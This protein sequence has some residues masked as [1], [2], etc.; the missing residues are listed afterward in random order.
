MSKL[1]LALMVAMAA[2]VIPGVGIAQAQVVEYAPPAEEIRPEVGGL[3]GA[4]ASD[5][6]LASAAGLEVLKAGG[7]AVDAAVTMAAM[8]AVLRPHMNSVGGDAFALFYDAS[9]S[10]VTALNGSGRAPEGATPEF[11]TAQGIDRMPGSGPHSVTV[12]GTVSAWAEALDRYGS[13]TLAEALAPAIAIAR[14]GFMVTTTLAS[15]LRNAAA[16]LNPGGQ[17]IYRPGDRALEAG[18]ILRSPQLGESLAQIA[19]EGP[20]AIYGG[21][22]GASIAAFLESEG[23]AMRVSD[24]AAHQAE[25]TEPLSIEFQGRHVHTVRP[26]SQ[27]ISLLQMLG[28]IESLP[29]ADREPNS[30]RLMHEMVEIVKLAFADRDYWVADPAFAEIPLDRLLER[31]YLEGRAA[32]ITDEAAQGQEG[33][34]FADE[35]FVDDNNNDDGRDGGGDTV[36]L[37][38]VDAD[39]NAVSWIQSIFGT[40]GSNLVDPGTGIVLQNRGAGF[41]LEEGSTNQIAPGKRPFHTLM[42]TMVT[43][44]NGAFEMTVGTPGGGGQPQFI[45]Q[46]L[47]HTLLFEMS[48]Q[49][50]IEAP[51]FRVGGGR[52]L[53]LEDRLPTSVSD[54]LA[55]RGHEVSLTSGWTANFGNMQV[56][57]RL[58]NGVLRTGADMRREGSA[59]A[60]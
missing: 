29:L 39:G 20:G 11:F 33:T 51:R 8:L 3:N 52:S 2:V 18:D 42:A 24:F 54:A 57:Q 4:V 13:Y 34:S 56:I 31:S 16:R 9:T 41:T 59:M 1:R 17:A 23:S 32:L 36:Y 45:A 46:T 43:D 40:F 12:P 22:I 35:F 38:A 30:E 50:A 15:D 5:H 60:Y 26:N 19:A 58:P 25:W 27:G 44:A 37:M 28:M 21:S 6:P 14:D 53:S 48:P 7:N 10:S 55:G 47:V 49:R